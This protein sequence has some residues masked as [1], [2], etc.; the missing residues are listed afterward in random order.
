MLPKQIGHFGQ[1]LVGLEQ[2]LNLLIQML[3]LFKYLLSW[4]FWIGPPADVPKAFF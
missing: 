2:N 1:G 3:A 4:A